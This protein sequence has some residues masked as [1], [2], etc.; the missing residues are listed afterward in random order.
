MSENKKKEY[1]YKQNAIELII[2]N[3]DSLEISD[4]A[5]RLLS[6]LKN[7]KIV[8]LSVN[9]SPNSGK[10][11]LANNLISK[12][13]GFDSIKNKNGIWLWGT[14]INLKEGL[15][16][17]I[18]YF[19]GITDNK[20]NNMN[21]LN[22]LFSTHYIFNTKGEINDNIMNNYINTINIKDFISFKNNNYLPEIVFINDSLSK[23]Q[24]KNK[25]ENNT[26]YKNI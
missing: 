26:L 24:I 25:I 23:E 3:K 9:G 11:E 7:Q 21:I 2:N 8:V 14:P 4:E 5:L 1:N 10:T 20:K 18:L 6:S 16:L 13:K 15:K 22:I 12:E 19:E 17:L